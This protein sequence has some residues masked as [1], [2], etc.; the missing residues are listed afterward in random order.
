M[1]KIGSK[2]HTAVTQE[3]KRDRVRVNAR[4]GPRPKTV[5]G[6]R[7]KWFATFRYEVYRDSGT[8]LTYEALAVLVDEK[9]KELQEEEDDGN[10]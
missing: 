3:L 1:T 9:V 4:V 10:D 2:A 7:E 6:L 8:L 5:E